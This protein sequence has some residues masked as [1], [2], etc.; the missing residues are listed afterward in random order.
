M[1]NVIRVEPP[2]RNGGLAEP[3]REP[4]SFSLKRTAKRPRAFDGFELCTSTSYSSA[5]PFWFEINA[6][7]TTDEVYVL[8]VKTLYKDEELRDRFFVWDFDTAENLV[9]FLEVYDPI[10]G[11]HLPWAALNDKDAPAAILAL[12]GYQLRLHVEEARRQFADLVG[13]VLFE[14]H[15]AP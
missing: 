14:I 8:E 9:D 3:H 1:D 10:K 6:Y 12:G 13:E 11:M 4:R 2:Q 15:A 5:P 7:K